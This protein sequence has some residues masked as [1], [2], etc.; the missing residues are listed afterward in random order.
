M[1]AFCFAILASWAVP[2][3]H[4][5]SDKPNVVLMLADNAGWGDI[6]AFGGGEMRGMPTPNIDR[7]ASE[8]MQFTQYLVEPGCTPSRAALLTGRYAVRSGL[9]TIIFGG[10]GNTLQAEEH[11]LAEVFKSRGYDTAI[12]GKWHVGFEEQSWPTRQG[13]DEYKVGVIETSDATLYRGNME[14]AKLP[15]E[16][17]QQSVPHIFESDEKGNLR[18]VREYTLGYRREVEKDI[19]E[20]SVDYIKRHAKGP[21]PFFLYVGW[22]HPHYPS[23]TAPEFTGRSSHPY[24]D[25]IMELD[26]RTGQ[27]LEAIRDAGIEDDTIVIWVTDNGATPTATIPQSRGGSNGPFRGELGDPNEGSIRAPG[28][29]RWPGKIAPGKNNEMIAIHDFLPTL[30]SIIGAKLPDDR[31]YDGVDQ[32]KFLLGEQEHSN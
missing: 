3:A 10:A 15:E 8:G 16:L 18:A 28:M 22:T 14:R 29:I 20:A 11:T 27:V 31:P 26:H 13:F 19:A 17:I 25:A 1:K 21:D 23:V 2:T 5:Q 30:A 32:S 6:G 4:A 24:G 9:G 7:L 12:F